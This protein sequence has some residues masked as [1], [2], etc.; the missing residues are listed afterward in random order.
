M[1]QTLLGGTNRVSE[2]T[3][4]VKL[5]LY[6]VQLYYLCYTKVQNVGVFLYIYNKIG[7]M[8]LYLHCSYE[9]AFEEERP[10]SYGRPLVMEVNVHKKLTLWNICMP[11]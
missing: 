8:Y 2:V 10:F 6:L 11:L 1:K 9:M 7:I 3:N 4:V 5:L